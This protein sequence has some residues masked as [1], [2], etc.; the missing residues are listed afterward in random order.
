MIALAGGE[1]RFKTVVT[2]RDYI[3]YRTF[4]DFCYDLTR[5]N[6]TWPFDK[7]AIE[8]EMLDF[9]GNLTIQTAEIDQFEKAVHSYFRDLRRVSVIGQRR[10][11]II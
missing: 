1:H 2:P 6:M 4:L 5:T 11:S 3:V 7:R 9:A 8:F 10:T